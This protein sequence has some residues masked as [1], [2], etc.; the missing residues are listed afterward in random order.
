LAYNE[1]HISSNEH[2]LICTSWSANVD[3]LVRTVRL[4]YVT[5]SSFRPFSRREE[6]L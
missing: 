2:V 1:Q 3:K 4:F 6:I 5:G